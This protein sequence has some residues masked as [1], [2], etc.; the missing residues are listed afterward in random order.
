MQCVLCVQCCFP[1]EKGHET[2]TCKKRK[3]KSFTIVLKYS[4]RIVN[5]WPIFILHI[6]FYR[7]IKGA[8][9]NCSNNW[10]IIVKLDR[11]AF[12]TPT[13]LRRGVQQDNLRYI[14]NG[15]LLYYACTHWCVWEN[16]FHFLAILFKNHYFF[17]KSSKS[18]DKFTIIRI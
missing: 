1:S 2:A 14:M 3:R 8:T 18:H 15:H 16:T 17:H 5:Y 9:T 11:I 6:H 12:F 13:P 4:S 10:Q 7:V